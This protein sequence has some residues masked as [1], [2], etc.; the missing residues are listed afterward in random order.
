MEIARFFMFV[1]Y[2]N[3]EAPPATS[4]SKN[5]NF[6]VLAIVAGGLLAIY[7]VAKDRAGPQDE[8][9]QPG[10]GGDGRKNEIPWPWILLAFLVYQLRGSFQNA[11]TAD[12]LYTL[13]AIVSSLSVLHMNGTL[14]QCAGAATVSLLVLPGLCTRQS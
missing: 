1:L 2:Y 10:E 9:G 7:L 8:G 13:V 6:G 5:S 3:M 11:V 14:L 4:V 12:R